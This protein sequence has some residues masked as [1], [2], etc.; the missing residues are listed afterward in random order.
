ME[1]PENASTETMWKRSI[2][3]RRTRERERVRRRAERC[4]NASATAA[5]ATRSSRE[6]RFVPRK[7]WSCG[8]VAIRL[9]ATVQRLLS[10]MCSASQ[11]EHIEAE[12]RRAIDAAM[13][14]AKNSPVPDPATAFEDVYI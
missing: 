8:V 6:T 14:F 7:K 5:R 2:W 1:S 10:S 9:S 3:Q 13:E 11:L 12:V 4:S